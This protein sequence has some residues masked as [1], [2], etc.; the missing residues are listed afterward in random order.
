MTITIYGIKSCSTMKKAFT[1]LNDLDV[2]YDFHDYKKQGVDK[3][4]VQR[5]V[6]E[7][8]IE[9]VLNKRGTT[10]RKLDESQKQAADASVDTAIDLLVENTSMIKRPIVEGQ[11]ADKVQAVL[12]CG[13]D[14]AEFDKAF[15]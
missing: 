6:N 5:W 3:D 1:K 2:S 12:L 4:T 15:S 10:W 14:E 9:K 7:L 8:G 13:F 11:L